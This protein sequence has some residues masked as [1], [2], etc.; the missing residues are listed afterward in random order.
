MMKRGNFFKQKLCK[1]RH[2]MRHKITYAL[3]MYFLII[4]CK[5]LKIRKALILI[6]ADIPTFGKIT[7]MCCTQRS[8]TDEEIRPLCC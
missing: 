2:E 7:D 5:L 8:C 4:I 3:I 1:V 6:S